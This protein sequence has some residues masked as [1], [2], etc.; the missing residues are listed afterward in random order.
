MLQQTKG[1]KQKITKGLETGTETQ[2]E[3]AKRS[4]AGDSCATGPEDAGS[5]K[6]LSK[7]VCVCVCA[8]GGGYLIQQTL[9]KTETSGHA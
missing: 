3:E 4:P 5:Q 8:C 1:G 9:Q 6:V 2:R 7:S